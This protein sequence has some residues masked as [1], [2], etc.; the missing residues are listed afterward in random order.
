MNSLS[1]PGKDKRDHNDE[2]DPYEDLLKKVTSKTIIPFIRNKEV[3]DEI[4]DRL[5]NYAKAFQL[6]RSKKYEE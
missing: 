5:K 1:N 4:D 6:E 3:Q 2:K